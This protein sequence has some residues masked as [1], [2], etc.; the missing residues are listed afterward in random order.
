VVYFQIYHPIFTNVGVF[1]LYIQKKT[2]KKNK[3]KKTN[4][5][6]KMKKILLMLVILL[7][8]ISTQARKFYFST[9]GSDS[10][11]TTQ[12]Q[13]SATPWKTLVKLNAFA[14]NGAAAGDTFLFKRGDV[15]ANGANQ[16]GSVK[17]YGNSEGYTCATGTAQNPIVFTYY[18]DMNLERPNFLFPFPSSVSNTD[19]YNMI[20]KNVSYFVFD[21]LQFN[22]IRFPVLDKRTSCYTA[23]GL[24]FGESMSSGVD[25]FTVKNCNFTNI[26]YGILAN[27]SD[28]L[29]DNNTFTNF[30][31]VGDTLGT[32]DIGADA[33]QISGKK[34]RITNNYIS[35]SWAYANPYNSSSNGLLGGALETINDFD[36]SFIAYNT[37]IDNSGGMEFGQNA[38]TQYGPNDDTFAYNFF[39]NN[40]NVSYVNTTGTFRCAAARLHFWNNVIIENEKSRFTG[41]NNGGDA[42]GNGQTYTSSGFIYWPPLPPS[43]STYTPDSLNYYSS[44]RT[45]D[46]GDQLQGNV[47]DTLY[48]IKNNIIWNTNGL[49]LKSSVARRP[50]DFYQNN[51]YHIKGS[52]QQSTNL[53]D[54]AVLSSG[55][56]IINTDLFRDTSNAFPQ[57]WDF[58][59]ISDSSYAYVSRYVNVGLTRDY[60]GNL[61]SATPTI[62]VYQYTAPS[63]SDLQATSTYS[64]VLCNGGNSTVTVTATGGTPPYT[65]VGTF[66]RTSGAYVYTVTDATQ[67]TSTTSGVISQPSAV[68]GT[69]NWINGLSTTITASVTAS[70]GTSPYTYS[71]NATGLKILN[72]VSSTFTGVP[73]GSGTITITDANSCQYT[74][75]YTINNVGLPTGRTFYVS[76]SG[77]DSYTTTQA[78]NPSTPWA[79]LSKV[80][81]SLSTFTSGDRILFAK[82]SKFT[83]TL[84]MYGKTNLYFG[85]YGSGNKPLFWGTGANIVGL[86]TL[87]TCSNITFDGWNISD[88]TISI[89]D[90]TVQAKI[91]NVFIIQTSSQTN[92]VKNCTMDRMGYGVYVTSSSRGQTIDGNDIGNL[93]MIRNTPTSV[94]ADDDYGGV[95]VQISSS[96]NTVTN[97]YFHDCYAVSYDYGYDGGGVEFFE[98]GD[99]VNN[100]IIMY[101]TFYD[102]N[103][104]VEFGSNNDNIA[105]FLQSNNVIAYNKIINSSSLVYINN[106]GQY[107]TDVR[108]LQFYNNVILQTVTSRTGEANIIAM[109]TSQATEGIIVIKNN[110]FQISNGASV[111][112]SGQ[113]TAGQLTHTNNIYKLSG[114][115][116]ANFTLDETERGSTGNTWTDTSN[117]NPLY[118]NYNLL[119]SSSYAIGNGVNVGLTRDFGGNTVGSTPSIGIYNSADSTPCSFTYGAWTNC[120]NGTQTRT[121]TKTPAVCTG[122]PDSLS[123][124]CVTPTCSFTYSAWSTCT[125]GTQTRTYTKT[126]TGCVG[127]PDSLSRSCTVPVVI[128]KF[129]YSSKDKRISITCNVSGTMIIKKG[130][131]IVRTVN[132]AA[133]GTT[134]SVSGLATGTYTASTYGSTITF[135]R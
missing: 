88:T 118:W 71:I 124:S 119:P 46:C 69:V 73:Y 40:S 29:I 56:K 95:P 121:Y 98:E 126:P 117:V 52:Y 110:I 93:R 25:H 72:Q 129:S 83:G 15:F 21:G 91:Q 44:W 34:Y 76:N 7:S 103:G 3:Q 30:K 13:N 39:I 89:T 11:T 51:I 55:E 14:D 77:S 109:A 27:G 123:R 68:S 43:K 112:R 6:K 100:N 2:N 47:G 42:L 96:N 32:F 108:N 97:N 12:A 4:K 90:R 67:A 87:T 9:S 116:V 23:T 122:T 81:S 8:T 57:N 33:L 60:A 38:G 28:F 50:R 61:V 85:S 19:R 10:Y 79:T 131:A 26:G 99:T 17:W 64:T 45:F 105:N 48:D 92:T 37:F 107:K 113:W 66:T 80:Q 94:N 106:S 84:N 53:G 114:G 75:S 63:S 125:N 41:R 127:S 36:S 1:Y 130:T 102:C 58:H 134:V 101:N 104:I 54:G 5:N 49:Q 135:K 18:G 24:M 59:I 115:S 62:G 86:V 20:F 70:G 74:T 78:Q 133:K 22:D 120:I 82:G 128:S 16:R 31:S 132:Y 35:G 111:A 65:G